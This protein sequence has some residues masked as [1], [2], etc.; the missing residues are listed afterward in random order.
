[1]FN[2]PYVIPIQ[3]NTKISS[4]FIRANADII[5][6]NRDNL[7]VCSNDQL[8]KKMLETLWLTQYNARLTSSEHGRWTHIQFNSKHDMTMFMLK[9]G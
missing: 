2:D 8:K 9:W 7:T 1:M 4:V 5:A 6:N 3:Q